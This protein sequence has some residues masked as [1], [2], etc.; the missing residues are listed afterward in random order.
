MQY[1]IIYNTYI[2]IFRKKKFK[3]LNT[4]KCYLLKLKEYMHVCMHQI[5]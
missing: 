1:I 3:G 2:S 4:N 5:I